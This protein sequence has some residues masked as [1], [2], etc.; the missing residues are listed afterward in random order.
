MFAGRLSGHTCHTHTRLFTTYTPHIHSTHTPTYH[1]QHIH[2]TYSYT[3]YNTHQPSYSCITHAHCTHKYITHTLGIIHTTYTQPTHPTGHIPNITP[4]FIYI[5]HTHVCS[6]HTF[7][8]HKCNT[9]YN[10]ITSHTYPFTSYCMYHT[11]THTHTK[12][13]EFIY[14]RL[15]PHP[16]RNQSF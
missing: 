8:T 9:R 12:C 14:T 7:Y 6:T 2:H 11:Y 15:Q 4:F 13:F 10:T 16:N 5:H 3:S 1:M